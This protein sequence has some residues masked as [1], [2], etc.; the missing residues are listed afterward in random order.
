MGKRGVGA[1]PLRALFVE[2]AWS[3][4]QWRT[5]FGF[6]GVATVQFRLN[7]RDIG[8]ADLIQGSDR[9]RP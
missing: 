1:E 6:A 5:N 3:V 8:P 9:A 2:C 4:E 7:Y